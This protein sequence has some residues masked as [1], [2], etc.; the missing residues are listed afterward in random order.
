MKKKLYLFKIS[1]ILTL[2]ITSCNNG[3]LKNTETENTTQ[4]EI[5]C[6]CSDLKLGNT[7][8]TKDKIVY[9]D[10]IL[11]TG[12][13]NET[14]K[15]DSIIE[16][17]TFEKGFLKHTKIFSRI[18]GSYH[19]VCDMSYDLDGNNIDGFIRTF[20]GS[21]DNLSVFETKNPD[22]QQFI[23]IE[24]VEIWEKGKEIT[25]Y[26]VSIH[27]DIL[28]EKSCEFS[29]QYIYK[30]GKQ[31]FNN[32]EVGAP[33]C[34]AEAE[35]Q[36]A[37][38]VPNRIGGFGARDGTS[39]YFGDKWAFSVNDISKFNKIIDCFKIEYPHF[40]FFIKKGDV[41]KKSSIEQKL[42]VLT[43]NS[44]ENNETKISEDQGE[45]EGDIVIAIHDKVYFYENSD[46]NSK[47]KSYFVKGQKAEYFEISDDDTEDEFLYVN[48]TYKGKTISGYILKSDVKFK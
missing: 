46:L 7:Q 11:F 18:L 30:D 42:N 8:K 27:N 1:S 43:T 41:T 26:N 39:S 2:I 6:N 38:S 28:D 15:F 29:V 48:F 33:K 3:D 31:I 37:Y 20:G 16:T 5:V 10:S 25:S 17:K 13:C 32:R 21:I 14:D 47:T 44:K 12:K 9:Q 4:Q 23:Y 35:F 24:S 22:G 45:P 19:L 40:D 34:L 36:E